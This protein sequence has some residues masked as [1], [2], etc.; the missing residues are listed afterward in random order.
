[1]QNDKVQSMFLAPDGTIQATP[2]DGL[3]IGT[4]D[5]SDE[6]WEI[7]LTKARPWRQSVRDSG[8]LSHDIA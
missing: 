3:A 2:N 8:Y 6:Q 1:P 5:P 7:P 4:I